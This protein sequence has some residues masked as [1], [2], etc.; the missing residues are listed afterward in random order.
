MAGKFRAMT[1]EEMLDSMVLLGAIY[2][3]GHRDK[4]GTPY[5]LHT[6]AVANSVPTLRMKILAYGH[7]LIEDTALTLEDM[8]KHGFDE[9]IIRGLDCLTW[10]KEETYDQYISRLAD[11]GH[12]DAVMVKLADLH[13]NMQPGRYKREL[14][15]KDLDRISKYREAELRLKQAIRVRGYAR[16]KLAIPINQD[17]QRKTTT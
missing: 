6:H 12:D 1:N 8:R 7:D 4:G 5:V 10:R 14:T 17:N 13:H 9:D 16:L 3:T 15:P 2:H 11:S